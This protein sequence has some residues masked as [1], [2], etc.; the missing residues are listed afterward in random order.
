[1]F[2]LPAVRRSRLYNSSCPRRLLGSSHQGLRYPSM[3]WEFREGSDLPR[4][5]SLK[6]GAGDDHKVASSERVNLSIPLNRPWIKTDR[7]S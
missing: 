6:N 2:N 7:W 4:F 3:P 5:L 1:M